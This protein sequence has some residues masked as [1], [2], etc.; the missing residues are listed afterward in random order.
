MTKVCTVCGSTMEDSARECL[1]CGSYSLQKAKD[2]SP[3][4]RFREMEF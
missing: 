4:K 2:K 3:K 1:N